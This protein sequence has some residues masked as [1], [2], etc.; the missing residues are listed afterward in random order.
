MSKKQ[1]IKQGHRFVGSHSSVKICRWT[2]KSLVDEGECYKAKFYG[3][4]S[5]RCCC[6]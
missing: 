4:D 1:L 2:G 6:E 5:H 3:I